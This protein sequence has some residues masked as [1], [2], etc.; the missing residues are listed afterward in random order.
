ML[1]SLPDLSV[2]LVPYDPAWP[3]RF[4]DERI[5]ISDVLGHLIAGSIEHVGS[6]A[7]P[8]LEAKPILDIMV[9]IRDL[10]DGEALVPLLGRIGY[11]YHPYRPEVMHWFCK[12]SPSRRT[13]HV[14][15]VPVGSRTWRERLAFRDYL[16]AH[17]EA[18]AAYVE[19]KRQLA[20]KHRFDR[21]AYTEAKSA[22]IDGVL[23]TALPA[24][25][26]PG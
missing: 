21:E 23:A 4:D 7:V 5:A 17:A 3:C 13:H 16:R 19:L 11:L 26:G 2:E 25:G 12:P 1:Y 15:A 10:G 24:V 9:G 20:S 8:G 18:A 22:F 6:T 14:H